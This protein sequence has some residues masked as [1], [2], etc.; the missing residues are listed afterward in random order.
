MSSYDRRIGYARIEFGRLADDCTPH[1][2]TLGAGLAAVAARR[3]VDSWFFVLE[4]SD[5]APRINQDLWLMS[6][7]RV[8][9][10]RE[11]LRDALHGR[12]QVFD[13]AMSY[14]R[15]GTIARPPP[16]YAVACCGS[17]WRKRKALQ[18]AS[19]SHASACSTPAQTYGRR[20]T[21]GSSAPCCSSASPPNASGP[22]RA[23][24]RMRA[25]A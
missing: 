20:R 15:A 3:Q 24:E 5:G 12:G 2:L 9:L 1:Y 22:M 16:G 14:R 19:K 11:R 7:Q 23:P 10:T 21:A 13:T 17:R 8:V 18:S 4:D 6:D 25:A